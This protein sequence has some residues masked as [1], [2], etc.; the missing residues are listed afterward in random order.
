[1]LRGFFQGLDGL[2]LAEGVTVVITSDHGEEFLEHGKL[3]HEQV[4]HECLHVPL[5][6]VGPGAKPARVPALVQSID[7]APTLYEL[8]GVPLA[9]RP[10]ASGRSLVPL[11]GGAA[12]APGR[13]AY[14]EA[15]VTGDRTLYRQD[16]DGLHQYLRREPRRS[17]DSLWVTRSAR[18]ET[19]APAVE[20]WAASFHEPRPLRINVDGRPL[21]TERLETTE[22]QIRVALPPGGGKRVV[23]LASPTC[24]SPASLGQSSDV[25]CLS[26][27][28][29]GLAP[30]RSELY[31][32][33][34]DPLSARDLSRERFA[35]AAELSARLDA[36]RFRPLAE[37]SRPPLDPEQE[38][39]LK[40]LGYLQ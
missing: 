39:R 21:R 6:V 27:L 1:V 10:R 3:A 26:F 40:A 30:S 13:E 19:L 14:A 28:L 9:A 15:F 18:F 16:E 37:P 24:V 11:L 23:E 38:R 32:L 36:L 5:I 25:R 29:R 20:F 22:R 33:T 12:H 2:G 4:Y 17:G 8:A 34:R 7:I 31:D 35:L